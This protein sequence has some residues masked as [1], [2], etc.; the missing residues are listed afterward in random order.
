MADTEQFATA[1]AQAKMELIETD[2]ALAKELPHL[3]PR[4]RA[5]LLKTIFNRAR[6]IGRDNHREE[7][8]EQIDEQVKEPDLTKFDKPSQTWME[9]PVCHTKDIMQQSARGRRFQGCYKCGIL[10]NRDGKIVRM[11]QK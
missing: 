3:L 7:N 9:C 4:D 6:D 2:K 8:H 10:L 5:E 1:L 11:E